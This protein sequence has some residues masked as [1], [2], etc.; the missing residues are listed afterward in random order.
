M[1]NEGVVSFILCR[2]LYSGSSECGRDFNL[3]LQS[4]SIHLMD[5]FCIGKGLLKTHE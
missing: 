2:P 3:K 4:M 5:L 1:W